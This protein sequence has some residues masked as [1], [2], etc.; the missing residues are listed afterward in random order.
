MSF[1]TVITAK[2]TNKGQAPLVY[3]PLSHFNSKFFGYK[4]FFW[5]MKI[6]VK[7]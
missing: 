2:E 1:C 7:F 5:K 6:F 3:D 4:I